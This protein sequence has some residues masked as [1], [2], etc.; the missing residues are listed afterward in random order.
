MAL[1]SEEEPNIQE[2]EPNRGPRKDAEGGF[3]G[4]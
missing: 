4:N 2:T 1:P 3:V